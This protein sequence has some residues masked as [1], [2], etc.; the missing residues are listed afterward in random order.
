MGCHISNPQTYQ[1]VPTKFA[2]DG[3]VE[4]CELSEASQQLEPRSDRPNMFRAK[5]RLGPGE[6]ARVPRLS[7]SAIR[8]DVNMRIHLGSS[9]FVGRRRLRDTVRETFYVRFSS[10]A[11][12]SSRDDKSSMSAIDPKRT[13][14]SSLATQIERGACEEHAPLCVAEPDSIITK[15]RKA[16]QPACWDHNQIRVNYACHVSRA[17][18]VCNAEALRP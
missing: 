9:F 13:F 6:L 4:E 16:R 2:V 1:V 12:D 11:D 10:R 14:A 3:E 15:V 8:L 17:Q 18:H 5:R 7:D